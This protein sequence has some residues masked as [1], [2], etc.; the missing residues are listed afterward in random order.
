MKTNPH[1]LI[2][3]GPFNDKTG[4]KYTCTVN[5]TPRNGARQQT[6][7]GTYDVEVLFF[8]TVSKKMVPLKYV[9]DGESGDL[10][11]L[12]QGKFAPTLLVF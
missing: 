7:V 5:W 9:V 11:C 1:G 12:F 2:F 3:K 4:G 8:P 6:L 10:K